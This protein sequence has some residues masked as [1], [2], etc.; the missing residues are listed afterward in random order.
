MAEDDLWVGACRDYHSKPF[1]TREQAERWCAQ[2]EHMGNCHHIHEPV[3]LDRD[4]F[5]NLR[6]PDGRMVE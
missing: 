5:G 6:F 4:E 2:V 3:R 1:P